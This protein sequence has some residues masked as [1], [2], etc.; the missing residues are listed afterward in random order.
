MEQVLSEWIAWKWRNLKE[1]R[2]IMIL[3]LNRL[4]WLI[5]MQIMLLT[6]V[7]L[8]AQGQTHTV[9]KGDTLYSLS[10][11]YGTSVD[12]LMKLNRLSSSNLSIGQKLVVKAVADKPKPKPQTPVSKPQI[13]TPAPA[14]TPVPIPNSPPSDEAEPAEQQ[15][16]LT[17]DYYYIIKPKDNLYR[18][19]VNNGIT[20][21]EL[22]AWNGFADS[23]VPI[24]PGDKIIIKNP[25][26]APLE[27]QPVVPAVSAS[28]PAF[29]A[30]AEPDTVVIERVYVVQKKDTLFRIA[31][32]NG[33]TVDEI[34][35]LNNLASNEIKVGQKLY[36]AGK[37]KPG[38]SLTPRENLTDEDVQK[39]DKIRNDLIMPAE[40]KVISEYGLRNGRPHKGIDLG[41]KSGTPIYAVL[42][43]T[44]VYSGV[45]GSYGNVV[46]IEH[47]DFVMTVY[48]HNEKNLVSV[49]D[50]VTKGQQIATVGSTGNAQGSHVHFEYRLKGKAINPRKVLPLN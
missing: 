45:Q 38:E 30:P 27:L 34:R 24:H 43:G 7:W 33:M 2:S 37:P 8:F 40:S 12:E 36:L 22:L 32:N 28:F 48:A 9:R 6:P 19:A 25:E 1:Q 41:A 44:V 42:D 5:V 35:K 21:A 26:D 10:K 11:R 31:T 14:T 16:Q 39:R 3:K 50:V 4:L 29:T 17:T 49:N 23:S 20:M 18:V 46:V 13:T 15:R 47:P